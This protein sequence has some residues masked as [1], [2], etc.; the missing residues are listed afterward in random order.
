MY[1]VSVHVCDYVSMSVCVYVEVLS[2]NPEM[3]W[4]SLQYSRKLKKSFFQYK[5]LVEI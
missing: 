5:K 2:I 4:I 3:M 1:G